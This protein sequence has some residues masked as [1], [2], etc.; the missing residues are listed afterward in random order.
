MV[1]LTASSNS[2]ITQWSI[3]NIIK[4]QI[5]RQSSGKVTGRYIVKNLCQ[6]IARK[7][8]NF[9]IYCN[10]RKVPKPWADMFL[11]AWTLEGYQDCLHNIYPQLASSYDTCT[12]HPEEIFIDL[13]E[14]RAAKKY[15]S[16]K[17]I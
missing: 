8:S 3:R 10:F 13:L 17:T 12:L 5:K 7:P 2:S 16:C 11:L 4:N 1:V 9:D 6:I 14:Q 15:Q